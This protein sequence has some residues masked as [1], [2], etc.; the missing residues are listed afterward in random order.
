M[1]FVADIREIGRSTKAWMD[2]DKFCP[3]RFLAGGEA[4][5]VGPVPGPK[6]IRM[7]P[8]GAGR[9]YCPGV[10]VGMVQVGCFLTALVREF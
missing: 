7:L 6:E 8:F 5:G 9:R 3:E 4:E 1:L 2:P 10:G